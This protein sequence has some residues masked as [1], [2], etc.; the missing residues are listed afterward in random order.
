MAHYRVIQ[1]EAKI[2]EDFVIWHA[3]IRRRAARV[4]FRKRA[5]NIM[6][7][8]YREPLPG[9]RYLRLLILRKAWMRDWLMY[10]EAVRVPGTWTVMNDE[11]WKAMREEM[12]KKF[13]FICK[14]DVRD[15]DV[16]P[17]D[18]Y[19]KDD[20]EDKDESEDESED[21]EDEEQEQEL[22]VPEKTILKVR[23]REPSSRS[24]ECRY[25]P[26]YYQ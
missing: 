2:I 4:I 26:Y 23:R 1:S 14:V 18:D 9:S 22:D 7:R 5:D 15:Y 24:Q 21:T 25:D 8:L 10:H 3:R 6:F 19:P 12:L 13:T 11:D 17:E 16:S 20:V